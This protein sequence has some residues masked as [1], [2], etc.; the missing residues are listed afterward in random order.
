MP[1]PLPENT[2][3]LKVMLILE[4]VI[5]KMILCQNSFDAVTMLK[6]EHG[7]LRVRQQSHSSLCYKQT[8]KQ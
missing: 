2:H 4:R 3:Y 8:S 7:N 5:W 6:V 1:N